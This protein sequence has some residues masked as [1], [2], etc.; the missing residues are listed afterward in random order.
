MSERT[1]AVTVDVRFDPADAPPAQWDWA[2]LLDTDV[3]LAEISAPEGDADDEGMVQRLT[4]VVTFSEHEDAPSEWDWDDLADTDVTIVDAD[5]VDDVDG[6]E[7]TG[8]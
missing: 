6:T 7:A 5:E 8:V 1:Q 3:R 2:E 4:L